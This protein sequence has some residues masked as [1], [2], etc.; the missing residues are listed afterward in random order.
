MRNRLAGWSLVALL[1]SVGVAPDARAEEPGHGENGHELHRNH[2]SFFVG[3]TAGGDAE[4][5]GEESASPTLGLDYERRL[6]RLFG[7][8]FLADVAG[9]D[10][11][12]FIA[13]IPLVFHAGKSAKIIVAPGIE[14][15]KETGHDETLL[16]LGFMWDFPVRRMTLSPA[17]NVDMVH[18]E[19]VY[20]VG[21]NVGW[22]F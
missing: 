7:I 10:R 18:G 16:R 17:F 6:T 19:Q 2:F 11:R 3:I 21:L 1:V 4:G 22:G 12:E 14:R 20:V 13:A 5:D 8:G 9:G 15:N